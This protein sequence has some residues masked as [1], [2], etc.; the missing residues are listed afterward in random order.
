M[1]NEDVQ[2]L[3]KHF[4]FKTIF[5]NMSL[6][7]PNKMEKLS[8]KQ[9]RNKARQFSVNELSAIKEVLNEL[10]NHILNIDN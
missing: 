9:R 8:G 1:T 6:N 5:K 7:I 10:A 4:V 3:K 2:K